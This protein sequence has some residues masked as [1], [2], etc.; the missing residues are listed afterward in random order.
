[1]LDSVGHPVTELHR[2]QYGP[3]RLGGLA[4]GKWREL[5]RVETQELLTLAYRDQVPQGRKR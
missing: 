3:L 1:M 2:R 4:A 5:T